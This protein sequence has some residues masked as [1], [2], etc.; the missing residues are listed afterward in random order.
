MQEG[1]DDDNGW[2]QWNSNHDLGHQSSRMGKSEI[3]GPIVANMIPP[4]TTTPE[5]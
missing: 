5:W 1:R 4:N 2:R 3:R